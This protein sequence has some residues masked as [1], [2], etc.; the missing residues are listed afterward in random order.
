M[1][2][3]DGAAALGSGLRQSRHPQATHGSR[4][5]RIGTGLDLG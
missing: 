1:V 3:L 5:A 4:V 2:G